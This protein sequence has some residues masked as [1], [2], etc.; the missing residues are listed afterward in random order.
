MR[1]Q[2][3]TLIDRLILRTSGCLLFILLP[4]A[5]MLV[6]GLVFQV[7][8]LM[9]DEPTRAPVP[10]L[11]RRPVDPSPNATTQIAPIE[12]VSNNMSVASSPV[13]SYRPRSTPTPH[14]ISRLVASAFNM[15]GRATPRPELKIVAFPEPTLLLASPPTD[16]PTLTPSPIPTATPVPVLS[17]SSVPTAAPTPTPLAAQ[18]SAATTVNVRGGPGTDYPV[19]GTLLPNNLL[20]ITGRN[21]DSSWW[22][23]Q[24]VNGQTGWVAGWVVEAQNVAGVQIAASIPPPPQPSPPPDPTP[25]DTPVPT[26][27]PMPEYDYMLAEFYNSPTSNTFLTMFVA[28]V[29]PREIPIGDMKVV[30]TRLDHNLTYESPLSTWH[31]EGY[32]A[33]GKVIKSGNVKF[34]PPGGIETT[35]WLLHLEDAHGNRQ[36][37]DV[38]FDVD[39]NAAQ[40][41]FI[42]FRRKF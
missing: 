30:G 13:R 6:C 32:S 8:D 9:A 7:A 19:I 31:F 22:Q 16:T 27:S 18:V 12:E 10:G 26:P 2:K 5:F 25:V 24:Q 34:E 41:Y 20:P 23:V 4:L 17:P 37:E 40:W 38:P 21:Q 29:D 39:A 1:L 42:K 14:I 35:S 15:F 11:A 28:I 33:P 36:S 3:S